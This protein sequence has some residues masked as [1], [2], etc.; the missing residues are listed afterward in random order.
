MSH[1]VEKIEVAVQLELLQ[2]MY[3]FLVMVGHEKYSYGEEEKEALMEELR[4]LHPG[5]KVGG[6]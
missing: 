5:V 3:L 1:D 6:G 2:D 4:K